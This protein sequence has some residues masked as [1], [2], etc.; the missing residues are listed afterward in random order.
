VPH[1]A[2]PDN[3]STPIQHCPLTYACSILLQFDCAKDPC[4]VHR[5]RELLSLVLR[6]ALANPHLLLTKL[7]SSS[8]APAT[9]C[10]P[11]THCSY[12]IFSTTQWSI[13]SSFSLRS[14]LSTRYCKSIRQGRILAISTWLCTT[15]VAGWVAGWPSSV[16]QRRT[17]RRPGHEQA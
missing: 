15:R 1:H 13:G 12:A 17:V 2:A 7:I 4:R 9:R 5:L 16:C 14:H 6:I 8:A 11:C 10:A 3:V